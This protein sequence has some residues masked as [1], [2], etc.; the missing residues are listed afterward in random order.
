[1]QF[2]PKYLEILQEA[3]TLL[4]ETE[5]R[6]ASFIQHFPQSTLEEF[7]E[8]CDTLNVA[9]AKLRYVRVFVEPEPVEEA[10]VHDDFEDTLSPDT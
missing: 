1:M 2:D 10:D 9:G 3:H 6:L 4:Q 7:D 8:L 5:T